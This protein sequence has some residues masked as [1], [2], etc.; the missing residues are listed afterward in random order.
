MLSTMPQWPWPRWDSKERLVEDDPRIPSN[1]AIATGGG[2]QV[3]A[4]CVLLS[5]APGYLTIITAAA[6]FL[7][8]FGVLLQMK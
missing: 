6:L 1:A 4:L 5:G 7:I 2:L 3:I 8:A